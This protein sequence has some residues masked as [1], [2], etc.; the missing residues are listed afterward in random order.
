[1]TVYVHSAD[2]VT[3]D[4][5]ISIEPRDGW[6]P[7]IY[8]PPKTEA[9]EVC[10]ADGFVREGDG[11]RAVFKVT[12]V[13]VEPMKYS[14]LSI[15]RELAKLGKWDAAKELLTAS[16]YWDDYVLANY[17]S[18]TDPVFKTACAALVARGTVT[19]E[20]LKELLPK[21]VWTAD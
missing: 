12:K 19:D 3:V 15:K 13:E 1:M 9:D 20:E 2:G 16:G 7:C 11:F 6:T 8:E 17:L 4:S 5:G 18:E 21:C 14:T 10:V